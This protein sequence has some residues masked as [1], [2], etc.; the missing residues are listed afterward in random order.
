MKRFVAFAAMMLTCALP[1]MSQ[2]DDQRHHFHESFP[3]GSVL[4]PGLNGAMT[5]PDVPEGYVLIDGD[6]Q[7]KIDEY[8][9]Y[10]SGAESTFGTVTF[11]PSTVPFGFSANVN[12]TNQTRAINAMNAIAARAGITFVLRTNQSN[13]IQFN[14]STGNNSPVG[15]QGGTQTIN[16]VS[17]GTQI[18]ICHEIYHSLGFWHE[19]SRPDRN[20]FV[21]IN[22]ANVCQNC[23]SGGS[24]NHNFDIHT[25]ASTYG[26]YDFDSFMHYSGTAFSVNGQ[27]TI[28]VN[29][30]W[31][32]QWQNAIGQRNH[33]SYLDE[34]TC[35]GIYRFSVDRWWQAGAGGNG[36]GNLINPITQSTFAG[37]Y[38]G[39]PD[40]GTLFIKQPGTYSAVG[41]YSRPMNLV[42]PQGATLGN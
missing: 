13:W 25:G 6:I 26:F 17:W 2:V 36:S 40:F 39:T 21:T 18:V 31:T 32:S 4:V 24:C 5:H 7:V 22:L 16:I 9:A 29:Q 37:A 33:F 38:A 3:P 12:A 35:R 1:A 10:L 27:N 15:M 30:P 28:S 41:T 8:A 11:W 23:C 20:T 34:I 19:Q 42:A 14:D